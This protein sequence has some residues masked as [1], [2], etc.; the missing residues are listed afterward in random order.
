MNRHS[1]YDIGKIL[2][3]MREEYRRGIEETGE[4]AAET[5]DFL[6]F[7]LSGERFGVPTATAREVLRLPKLVRVPRVPESIQGVINLRGQIVAVTDLRP[8]LGLAGRE[9]PAAA[10]LIVAEAAGL[11]TALLAE[12]VDGI[13]SLPLDAIEPLTSGLPGF[14]RE[15]VAGQVAVDGGFLILLDLAHILSRPEMVIDQQGE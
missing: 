2:S 10:R 1:T 14:P 7:R 9:I 15:A 11:T 3:E 12:Q 5:G 6:V 13:R 4:A 8:L